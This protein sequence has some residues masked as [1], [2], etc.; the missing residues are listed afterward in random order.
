MRRQV[1]SVKKDD[2]PASFVYLLSCGHSVS[3]DLRQR[4]H[5]Q[6]VQPKT[7]VCEYCP[8]ICN[9]APPEI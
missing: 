8:A 4:I 6:R 3:G 2:R 5:G 9:P 1:K 7:A